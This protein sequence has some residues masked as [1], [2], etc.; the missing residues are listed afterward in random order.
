MNCSIHFFLVGNPESQAKQLNSR[1]HLIS[2]GKWLVRNMI[3]SIL[4]GFVAGFLAVDCLLPKK[5]G[6]ITTLGEFVWFSCPSPNMFFFSAA[7]VAPSD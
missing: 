7:L 1:N 3:N 5:H 4:D 2:V 6:F